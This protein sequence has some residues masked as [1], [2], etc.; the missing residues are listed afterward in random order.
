M[1]KTRHRIYLSAVGLTGAW[2]VA[3]LVRTASY[4]SEAHR[5]DG[6]PA[7]RSPSVSGFDTDEYLRRKGIHLH[8]VATVA[9]ERSAERRATARSRALMDVAV[10]FGPLLAVVGL[11]SYFR[12]LPRLPTQAT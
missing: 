9:Q 7:R 10:A 11:H 1:S 3:R 4:L 6:P 2:A 12:R 5:I 8:E